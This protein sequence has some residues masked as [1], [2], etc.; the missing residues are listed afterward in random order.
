MRVEGIDMRV[1]FCCAE[2]EAFEVPPG[3]HVSYDDVRI[4]CEHFPE[5]VLPVEVAQRCPKFTS[6]FGTKPANTK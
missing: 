2:A 1:C 5:G 3:C 6:I 4:I